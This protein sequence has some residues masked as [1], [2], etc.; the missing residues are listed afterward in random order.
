ME[1]IVIYGA[2]GHGRVVCDI[3]REEGRYEVAGFLDDGKDFPAGLFEGLPVLGG[4][5]ILPSLK[6]EGI[7][8]A[9]AAIGDGANR[10]RVSGL[11]LNGG[12][13][14]A[15]AVH[16]SV[17]LARGVF[18]GEGTVIAAGAIIN[19]GSRIGDNA[20]INTGAIVDHDCLVGDGAHICPG[21]CLAG[22]VRVGRLAW[23]GLGSRVIQNV[24]IGEGAVIGAGAVVLKDV[25]DGATAI[26]VPARLRR[27]GI[28]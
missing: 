20:I 4:K 9:I 19:P 15:K 17:H 21:A 12:L 7:R 11:L 2:S 18:I 27:D 28:S 14:L 8:W 26:G 22:G 3:I 6:N 16:P 24:S 10:L 5:E 25:P 1:K 13:M 23:V